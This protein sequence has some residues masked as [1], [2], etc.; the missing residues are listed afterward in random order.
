MRHGTMY[1]QGDI[2]LVPIPFSDL[3]N[4]KQRPVLII[5][6][7]SYN[8]IAKDLVVVAITS[9]LKN[10]DYSVIIESKDLLE[11]ELK[12][13]SEIRADKI[14]TLSKN[15]IRNKFGHVNNEVLNNIRA[16]IYDLIK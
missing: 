16:K 3:T 8:E 13:I 14:Y 11:G 12:K 9:K 5:S 4:T 7:N 2:V 6:S 1:K 10:L 15:I